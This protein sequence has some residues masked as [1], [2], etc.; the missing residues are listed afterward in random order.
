[1]D[2]R[3]IANR[4]SCSTC[5]EPMTDNTGLHESVHDANK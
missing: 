4:M 2:D 1:M 3:S 5:V